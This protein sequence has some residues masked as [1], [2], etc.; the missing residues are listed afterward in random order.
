M[1]SDGRVY[2]AGGTGA[3]GEPLATAELYDPATGAFQAATSVAG[4]RLDATVT[5]LGDDSVLVA[6][7]NDGSTTL[8]SLDLLRPVVIAATIVRSV[9]RACDQAQVLTGRGPAASPSTT[10]QAR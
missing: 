4:P 8:A 7:G 10:R 9:A 3:D 2:I 1:L 5:A 6:G